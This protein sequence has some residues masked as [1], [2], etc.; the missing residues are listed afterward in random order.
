MSRLNVKHF[1]SQR[2]IKHVR[3]TALNIKDSSIALHNDS[4]YRLFILTLRISMLH[5]DSSRAVVPMI[6][7]D[8]STFS[9]GLTFCCTIVLIRVLSKQCVA[10]RT[11]WRSASSMGI[12]P[13]WVS[14]SSRSNAVSQWC[15][16]SSSANP[17]VF[18]V[19]RNPACSMVQWS[20]MT[21]VCV[22][23]GW[24]GW[25]LELCAG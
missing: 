20:S 23:G 13:D 10:A 3:T 7:I 21:N 19:E 8:R 18:A 24:V 14:A 11:T 16:W 17:S 2:I 6:K 22:K 15:R 4:S 5:I 1:M 25:C 9:I 12:D